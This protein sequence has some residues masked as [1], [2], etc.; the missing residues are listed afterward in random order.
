MT[1]GCRERCSKQTKGEGIELHDL[2]VSRGDDTVQLSDQV[3]AVKPRINVLSSL[4]FKSI[5]LTEPAHEVDG[6]VHVVI[7]NSGGVRAATITTA[8]RNSIVGHWFTL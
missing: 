1:R 2:Y 7:F 8:I 5:G 3:V 4:L 6:I